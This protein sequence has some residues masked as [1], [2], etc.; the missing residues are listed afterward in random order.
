[1]IEQFQQ[2]FGPTGYL[3][4]VLATFCK[5]HFPAIGDHLEF[6]HKMQRRIYLGNEILAAILNFGGN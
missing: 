5:N 1:M 3:Q 4:S 2:N 6:L